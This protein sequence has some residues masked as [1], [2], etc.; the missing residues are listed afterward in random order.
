[1]LENK[2]ILL[3]ICGGIAAYKSLFLI[4]ELV[5]SGAEVKVVFTPSAHDFVTPLTASTLSKNPVLTHLSEDGEWNNH[6]ELG[7]WADL[8][9]IAPV[10]ANSIS[11]M[12]NG[13]CDNLLL[14]TYLSARCPVMI[15]PAMD[16][17]MFAHPSTGRN[18]E[19]LKK[20]NVI[21]IDPEEGELAS[22]LTGPG[23]MAEPEKIAER[24]RSFFLT[25][26]QLQGKEILITAG[27][28]YENI[29]PVRFIGNR[30]TGKM[31]IA[32]CNEFLSRGAKV[33]LILG[34]VSAMTPTNENLKVVSVQTADEMLHA[35]KQYRQIY[36]IAVFTAAVSD[37]KASGASDQ[38]I[39]KQNGQTLDLK[40]V[41]NPDIAFEMG[42][43]K[44][45][46]QFHVGF[47]L[48]T[49]DETKNA[50]KKLKAKNFDMI[51]L[52]SLNDKNTGFGFDTNKISIFDRHNNRTDFELKTK[53]E[54][55]KDIVD[56]I[57]Q[58]IASA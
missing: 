16:L 22:G 28:T 9:V 50:K 10:S 39:K 14:A 57:S 17:D 55:S 23:R 45:A 30:S 56:T 36:D 42:K 25:N 43:T 11:K 8:M 1:M 34:P 54:V 21:I 5:K 29:D 52:N 48:E 35:T 41:E 53:D 2:K 7:L 19:V 24:I 58:H 46:R 18:L 3:G 49:Q 26:S 13:G 15:A 4:R 27:P 20:D 44:S 31:G 33:T 37:Y 51:V 12:A 32:L 38:K 47:A 40:L 6:V